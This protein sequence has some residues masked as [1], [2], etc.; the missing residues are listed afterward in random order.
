MLFSV[1]A[2]AEAGARSKEPPVVEARVD[3]VVVQ[4]AFASRGLEVGQTTSFAVSVSSEGAEL[5]TA[6]RARLGMPDH[7]HWITEEQ[8][9][10]P[11]AEDVP[12][13]VAGA[14][15]MPGLYRLRI[16]LEYPDRESKTAVDFTIPDKRVR[17]EVV[18]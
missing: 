15:P 4:T 16:W 5:P 8:R 3:D 11:V 6:V 10:E 7:G 13:E 9:Q 18:P 17:P 1:P 2:T 12:M 14:L